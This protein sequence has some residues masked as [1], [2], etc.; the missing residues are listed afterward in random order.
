MHAIKTQYPTTER[1]R[2]SIQR[3]P[4]VTSLF[5]RR[6][7]GQYDGID[8]LVDSVFDFPTYFRVR[9]ALPKGSPRSGTSQICSATIIS[10]PT[11]TGW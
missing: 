7:D 5:S 9:E 11:P 6:P 1:G 2:R 4:A 8:D 10:I 3:D